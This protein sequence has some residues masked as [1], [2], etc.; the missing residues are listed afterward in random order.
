MRSELNCTFSVLSGHKWAQCLG[1]NGQ[2]KVRKGSLT[3]A[4]QIDEHC[5]KFCNNA[6]FEYFPRL[7]LRESFGG[8]LGGC[9]IYILMHE[10]EAFWQSA[11]HHLC[12]TAEV[13]N[14]D[15]T[16]NRRKPWDWGRGAFTA[17]EFLTPS[18]SN[19]K[20]SRSARIPLAERGIFGPL[21]L[22]RINSK[23]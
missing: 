11:V 23:G 16:E 7:T 22:S 13:R 10:V 15:R 8:G 6:C 12:W 21:P 5:L 4:V 1:Y 14:A 20:V 19:F 9:L 18:G 3:S 17:S 2:R